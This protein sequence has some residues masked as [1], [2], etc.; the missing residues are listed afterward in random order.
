MRARIVLL[1]LLICPWPAF[2]QEF[3]LGLRYS[4]D[5]ALGFERGIELVGEVEFE[6]SD[7]VRLRGSGNTGWLSKADTDGTSWG[8]SVELLWGSGD[9]RLRGGVTGSGYEVG[10]DLGYAKSAA[11]PLLGF[12]CD[13]HR[14]RLRWGVVAALK[15]TRAEGISE[16]ELE[17]WSLSVPVSWSFSERWSYGTAPTVTYTEEFGELYGW[18]IAVWRTW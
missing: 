6:L 14:D 15:P 17:Q 3:S 7:A 2:G 13:A 1:V 8:Y 11:G 5:S 10:G 4:D 18:S 9:C 16:E 12:E